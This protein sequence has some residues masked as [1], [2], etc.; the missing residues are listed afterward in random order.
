MQLL[1]CLLIERRNFEEIRQL[2]QGGDRFVSGE[3]SEIIILSGKSVKQNHYYRLSA[4][5]GLNRPT[6][7]AL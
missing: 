1:S 7:F 5:V 6:V 3:T 4:L 2:D